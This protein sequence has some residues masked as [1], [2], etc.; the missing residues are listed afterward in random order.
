MNEILKA[1]W[2]EKQ[3]LLD[4][5]HVVIN[6]LMVVKHGEQFSDFVDEKERFMFGN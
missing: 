6:I 1:L 3:M 4:L 2:P 5:L